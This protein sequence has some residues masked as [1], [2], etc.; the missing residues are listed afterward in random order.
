MRI[1]STHPGDEQRTLVLFPDS[2]HGLLDRGS[3]DSRREQAFG[4]EADPRDSLLFGVASSLEN[5]ATSQPNR[6]PAG[7]SVFAIYGGWGTGKTTFMRDLRTVLESDGAVGTVWFSLWQHQNDA[8][9]VIALL[10]EATK[11]VDSKMRRHRLQVKFWR[12]AKTAGLSLF[13][14]A[15]KA[16]STAT[17]GLIAPPSTKTIGQTYRS[18]SHS[19]WETMQDDVKRAQAIADAFELVKRQAGKPIVFFVDDIDRCLAG[20]AA[21]L[22]EKIRLYLTVDGCIFVIGADDTTIRRAVGDAF[23]S[24]SDVEKAHLDAY[25][26]STSLGIDE[27][28]EIAN[29]HRKEQVGRNYLEKIVQHAFYLP[30]LSVPSATEFVQSILEHNKIMSLTGV[31]AAKTALG[32]GVAGANASRREIIRVANAFT[33]NHFL[34]RPRIS[35]PYYPSITA[36]ITLIQVLQPEAYGELMRSDHRGYALSA[37]LQQAGATDGGLGSVG[38]EDIRGAA[39]VTAT[40]LLAMHNSQAWANEILADVPWLAGVIGSLKESDL[41][42]GVPEPGILERYIDYASGTSSLE[43]P[44]DGGTPQSDPRPRDGSPAD[45]A[46]GCPITVDGDQSSPR[47]GNPQFRDRRTQADRPVSGNLRAL[48]E[49][50][51]IT[52]QLEIRLGPDHPDTLTSRNNLAGAYRAAGNLN[53]AIPLFREALRGAESVL[54]PD[55]PTTK[56]IR[57]NLAYC[58]QLMRASGVDDNQP[59]E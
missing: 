6:S 32:S 22:L 12:V 58:E 40:M 7:S 8:Q 43:G 9:P 53:Q 51:N 42:R 20:V 1:V 4:K 56:T 16:V 11:L 54:G 24:K 18:M 47:E 45:E 33:L 39:G 27:R 31:D 59:E 19:A 15:G 49:L 37:I 5:I 38:N 13:N 57:D 34:S 29:W 48:L 36:L 50:A 46:M 26:R 41:V 21:D 3:V 14:M 10:H 23:M 17:L 2:D 25:A 52:H 44:D 30:A 28:R 35:A 55:H